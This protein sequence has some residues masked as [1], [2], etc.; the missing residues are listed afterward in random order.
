MWL[1]SYIATGNSA[2]VIIACLLDR[3]KN[4]RQDQQW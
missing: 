2:G 4:D 1:C 3:K